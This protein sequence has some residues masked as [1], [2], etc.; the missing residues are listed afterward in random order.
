MNKQQAQQIIRETFESAFDKNRFTGFIKNLLNGIDAAP[1]TYQGNYIP[2]PI[3]NTS[4]HWNVSVNSAMG[5][6]ALISLS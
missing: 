6:T 4:R 3:N 2:M 1:F 5:K